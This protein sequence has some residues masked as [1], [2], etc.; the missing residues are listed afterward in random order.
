MRCAHDATVDRRL[1]DLIGGLFR[2]ASLW[3]KCNAPVLAV[4]RQE[5]LDAIQDAINALEKVRGT[6]AKIRHRLIVD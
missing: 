4:E 1:E 5:Y 2:E 6:L 3:R